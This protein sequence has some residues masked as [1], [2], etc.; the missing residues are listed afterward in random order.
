MTSWWNL[1]YTG[2]FD[3]PSTHDLIEKLLIFNNEIEKQ[4]KLNIP[5]LFIIGEYENNKLKEFTT[6]F[7]GGFLTKDSQYHILQLSLNDIINSSFNY[8]EINDKIESAKAIILEVPSL[9]YNIQI[10]NL[11]NIFLSIITNNIHKDR[12]LVMYGTNKN[13]NMIKE[14]CYVIKNLT[15]KNNTINLSTT[16]AIGN[17]CP[18]DELI[19]QFIHQLFEDIDK[20]PINCDEENVEKEFEEMVGLQKVKEDMKEARMMSMFKKKRT[21]MYL[22]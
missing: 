1:L 22:T 21:D 9:N 12:T 4:C 10:V 16:N 8:K 2:L 3:I 14:N 15:N 20:K 11:I 17:Y 5:T 6:H 13:I 7:I 19:Q 18:D